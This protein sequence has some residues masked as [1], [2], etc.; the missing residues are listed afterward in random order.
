MRR[1][2]SRSRSRYGLIAVAAV[3]VMLVGGVQV[4]SSLASGRPHHPRPGSSPSI[5]G[6]LPIE[7]LDG[8]GNNRVHPSWGQAG[9]AYPRVTAARYADGRSAPVAGPDV[10]FISNRV[11]NDLHQNVF[12]ERRVS[13]WGFTWGQFLDHT[14][15]L[16]DDAG[17]KADLPFDA[18]DPLET[19]TNDLGVLPFTRSKAAAGTGTTNARQQ[20]NT[21]SSYLDAWAVYGGSADRL[22]WLREGPVDGDLGNNG[23]HLLLADGYL[24]RSD[25]RGDSKTAPPMNIDG[26]LIGQPAKAMVAGDRRANENTALTAVQT[27]FAREHNRI[28][29]Q[30]PRS[31]SEEERFQI[32]RRVVIA[33][34]QYITYTQFL[35]AMGVRLPAYRG[36]DPD[37]DAAVTNEFATVGY[38]AHSQIHGEFEADLDAATMTPAHLE[39]LRQQGVETEKSADG[40]EIELTIPLNVAFFNPDLLPL[41]GLGPMLTGLASESEYRNDEMIDNQLRSVLFQIPNQTNPHC[42]DGPELPKCFQGVLD[43]AALDIQRGRDHGMPGYNQ[44][45]RAYGLPPARSFTAVTGEKSDSP[46]RGLSLDSPAALEFT[47]LFD[48]EGHRVTP[49]TDA[50]ENTVVRVT[51]RTPLAARL[52][53]VYGSVDRLDAFVGMSSEPHVRGSELGPLQLAMWTRQFQAL[54]DGDRFFYGN[55]PGLELI[56]RTFGVDYRHSLG[57]LIA[58]NTGMPRDE[59]PDDVFFSP[60]PSGVA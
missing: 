15:G 56:K 3:I 5:L 51:R 20:I 2:K 4:H 7:S 38:R 26:R 22:E 60:P 55:D 17:A 48:A 19:F 39:A 21:V 49:G 1:S 28:V 37:V 24:P 35:P 43:L 31:L 59:L 27:L 53:G 9:Q 23:A 13:Q 45:R 47:G 34:Q 30:L 50:A 52:K 57:D 18:L 10:R 25:A 29:D 36:Y 16:R 6:R 54:R 40:E 58:Q 41:V 33:E 32:A 8:S 44:L 14:M 42:L 11:F 46:A 12:S